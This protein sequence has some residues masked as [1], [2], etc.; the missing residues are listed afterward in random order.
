MEYTLKP[1]VNKGL[2]RLLD[3]MT[4]VSTRMASPGTLPGTSPYTPPLEPAST[5]LQS[6]VDSAF[7]IPNPLCLRL[8]GIYS[9]ISPPR[10]RP[11]S[12]RLSSEVSPCVAVNSKAD[13]ESAKSL[14]DNMESGRAVDRIQNLAEIDVENSRG[15]NLT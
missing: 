13:D 9:S 7:P 15:S 10:Q 11:Y 8:I 2:E 4:C 12:W 6:R 3:R 1:L 5:R 14:V